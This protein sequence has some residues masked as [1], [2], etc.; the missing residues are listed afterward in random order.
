MMVIIMSL[1]MSVSLLCSS[2]LSRAI[3]RVKGVARLLMLST[4]LIWATG[5]AMLMMLAGIMPR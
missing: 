1:I 2:S 5:I 4:I 3:Y